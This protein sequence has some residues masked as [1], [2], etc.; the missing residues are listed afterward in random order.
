MLNMKSKLD[1]SNRTDSFEAI[2]SRTTSK[3]TSHFHLEKKENW[4]DYPIWNSPRV[5]GK[6]LTSTCS[7]TRCWPAGRVIPVSL[8]RE[9]FFFIVFLFSSARNG[10]L[11]RNHRDEDRNF[12]LEED[13]FPFPCCLF[14]PVRLCFTT[15]YD[16]SRKVETISKRS[17]Y[18]TGS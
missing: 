10:G 4:T 17:M 3:R 2:S 1:V 7:V 16:N 14:P 11:S 8:L 12:P 13:P 9:S 6:M 18:T 15:D 5:D